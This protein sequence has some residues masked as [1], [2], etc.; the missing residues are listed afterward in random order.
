MKLSNQCKTLKVVI[1]KVTHCKICWHFVTPS[2][3]YAIRT[4]CLLCL[5]IYLIP[6]YQFNK[7]RWGCFYNRKHPSFLSY[8][9]ILWCVNERHKKLLFKI[10]IQKNNHHKKYQSRWLVKYFAIYNFFH[11]VL[12]ANNINIANQNIFINAK[13]EDKSTFLAFSRKRERWLKKNG[14]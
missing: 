7:T 13:A 5:M 9:D 1:P 2:L 11:T 12:F 3:N 8:F 6:N 10:Y 4:I 14:D